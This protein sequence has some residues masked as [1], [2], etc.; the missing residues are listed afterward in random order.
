[1]SDSTALL[2]DLISQACLVQRKNANTDFAEVEIGKGD[3]GVQS[4]QIPQKARVLLFSKGRVRLLYLGRRN[5]PLFFLGE[6]SQ[7]A[8]KQKIEIYYNCNNIQE[9]PR[10][11]IK[12]EKD[13]N[14]HIDDD[15]KLSLFSLRQ[16]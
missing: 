16:D 9:L 12:N 7:L 14:A 4:L 3:Y 2:Q 6:G 8:V 10:L 11:M 13:S 5:R 1:V 15:V